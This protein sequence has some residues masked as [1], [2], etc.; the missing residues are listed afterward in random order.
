[1]VNTST[2]FPTVTN[3]IFWD[4]M[5]VSGVGTETPIVGPA[6]V[7]YSLVQRG[8]TGPGGV[9]NIDADPQFVDPDGPDN[10]IGTRDDNLR[11]RYGSP[12]IDAGDNTA[13]TVLADLD[14]N[15]RFV[16]DPHTPDTGNGTPPIVD[17]GAY[18]F[19]NSSIPTLSEWGLM[20][21]MLV[22]LA[23]GTAIIRWRRLCGALPCA[24]AAPPPGGPVLRAWGALVG[25]A[26]CCSAAL[27][28][29][30]VGPQIRIDGDDESAA[31]NETSCASSNFN[32]N[33]IVANGMKLRPK[34]LLLRNLAL[35]PLGE[36]STA[37]NESP[38]KRD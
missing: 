5:D 26:L 19:Q 27:A 28:Q 8:W 34:S 3:C 9:G 12:A 22:L 23:A 11:L 38:P 16:D 25:V 36:E 37:K 29:I 32:P 20:A 33:E 15:P 14:G 6:Q 35:V 2:S 17:M 1:M 18:E 7:N 31:A 21:L 30:Q 10:I 13:V 24:S 4:N